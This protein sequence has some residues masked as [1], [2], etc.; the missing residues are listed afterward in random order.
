[1]LGPACEDEFVSLLFIPQLV[2][3]CT[4]LGIALFGSYFIGNGNMSK[5]RIVLLFVILLSCKREKKPEE[6]GTR[7]VDKTIREFEVVE[8]VKGKVLWRL[9]AERA[10]VFRD[11]TLIYD[12]HLSFYNI[13]G[14]ISSV[15]TSDSGYVFPSGDM[16]AKGNVVVTSMESGRILKTETLSWKQKRK[17]IVSGDS[18]TIIVEDGVVK[19]SGFESNPNLTEMKIKEMRAKG[20]ER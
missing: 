20:E 9:G 11:T 4:N 3:S 14:K 8:T 17:K 16:L 12:V 19:G 10:Y 15:L 5:V 18:V 7:P 13:D 2:I 1:V 6:I